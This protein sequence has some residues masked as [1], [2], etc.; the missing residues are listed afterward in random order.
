MDCLPL[1][2]TKSIRSCFNPFKW[3][4]TASWSSRNMN[5]LWACWASFPTDC[6]CDMSSGVR[7]VRR[8]KSWNAQN[9][10][11]MLE[12]SHWDEP[13]VAF[14]L[15][16]DKMRRAVA[17]Q[18]ITYQRDIWIISLNRTSNFSGSF[19]N[20]S[21][22][23]SNSWNVVVTSCKKMLCEKVMANSDLWMDEL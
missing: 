8:D 3:L 5:S 9:W 15:N 18:K 12:K 20:A 4:Q 6:R 2:N 11:A 14:P 21:F 7:W 22:W 10:R 16:V 17:L 13:T 23:P 1:S 19:S